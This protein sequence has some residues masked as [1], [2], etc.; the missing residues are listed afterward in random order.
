MIKNVYS[1]AKKYFFLE[2]CVFIS[3]WCELIFYV[4]VYI[5]DMTDTCESF[6]LAKN[7]SSK[8]K[9]LALITFLY[10]Y[11]ICY[12]YTLYIIIYIVYIYIIY[13]T[14]ISITEVFGMPFDEVA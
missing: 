2:N 7:G 4:A 8:P 11:I 5:F 12:I 13:I 1:K 3:A 9:Q 14:G 10:I 6:L